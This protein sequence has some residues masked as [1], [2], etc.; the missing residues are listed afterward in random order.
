[1]TQFWQLVI[2]L[3][4]AKHFMKNRPLLSVVIPTWNRAR[5]VCEAIDCAL[6]QK[7]GE[8]EVI[9]IDDGATDDTA[10]VVERRFGSSIKLLRMPRQGGVAAAR[11]G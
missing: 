11:T 9:V 5:L 7:N 10:E 3:K 4:S 1:M 2:V 8:V 6:G